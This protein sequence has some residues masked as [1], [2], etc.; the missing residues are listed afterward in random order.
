MSG[1]TRRQFGVGIAAGA[2]VLGTA[3]VAGL[4]LAMGG[5]SA[6][7]FGVEHG[8]LVMVRVGNGQHFSIEVV[9]KASGDVLQRETGLDLDRLFDVRSDHVKFYRVTPPG[10]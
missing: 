6:R 3:G 5:S 7:G 9:D 1:L 2:V 4:G 10:V 8:D